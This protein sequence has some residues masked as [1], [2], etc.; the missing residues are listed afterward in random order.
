M[1]MDG[2][3][4]SRVRTGDEEA[5]VTLVARYQQPMFRLACSMVPSQ[6][7][8]EEAVQDNVACPPPAI[9]V[10]PVGAVGGATGVAEASLEYPL[11][12]ELLTAATL[13]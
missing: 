12:P 11:T 4:L 7:V 2:E 8:A 9:A 6:Q 13:K 3:L 10:R 1:E 5:F